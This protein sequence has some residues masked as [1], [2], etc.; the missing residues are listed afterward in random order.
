MHRIDG[1]GH[2]NNQ[3]TEGDPVGGVTAT[4]VTADW[5]NAVQEELANVI[6]AAGEMLDK[7]DNT[8]LAQ[9]VQTRDEKGAADGYASLDSNGEVPEAQLPFD[10]SQ[11]MPTGVFLPWP[12]E[13][14]D[15][16]GGWL[17]MYGQPDPMDDH[18]T[19]AR[20][21]VKRQG[22]TDTPLPSPVGTFTVDTGT[23]E[24]IAAAHGKAEGQLL[25]VAN[26]GGALPAGLVARTGLY[27]RNPSTDRY[28]VSAT[29]TGSILTISDAGS[30]TH[31]WYD[32]ITI[33]DK[34][35]VGIAGKD[36]MGGVSAN[37]VTNAEG[38]KLGGRMGAE[39]HVLSAAEMPSHGHS[40]NMTGGGA[41]PTNPGQFENNGGGATFGGNTNAAGSGAAHNNMQPTTFENM[42]IKT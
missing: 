31:S 40:V 26:S 33:P 20:I 18:P 7:G 28:Q 8:Q 16:P 10:L 29:P 4:E 25:H 3:F 34:R 6:E 13:E 14:A 42:I 11:L 37:R 24:I 35:G 36:D 22:N 32:T 41:G 19:L 30:G 17:L 5:A 2:D 23:D 15:V 9:V 21:L 12:G 27:V 1:P 39:T 38:D